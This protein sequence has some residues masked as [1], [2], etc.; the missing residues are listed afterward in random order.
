MT[1]T[2]VVTYPETYPDVIPDMELEDIDEES[3]TLREGEADAVIEQ[4]KQ[5]VSTPF[6]SPSH[7]PTPSS[8]VPS[9]PS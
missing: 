2:L 1:V 3:G 5:T 9:M 7:T 4:L 8:S 6:P